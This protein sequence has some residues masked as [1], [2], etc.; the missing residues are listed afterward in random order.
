MTPPAESES[1]RDA[2]GPKRVVVSADLTATNASG[3]A[4]TV[5]TDGD[6]TIRV[7]LAGDALNEL[8]SISPRQAT[9]MARQIVAGLQQTVELSIDGRPTLRLSPTTDADGRVRVRTKVLSVLS[10]AKSLLRRLRR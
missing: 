5:K 10:V 3:V 1:N 2:G 9:S 8:P 7:D 6:A 4:M